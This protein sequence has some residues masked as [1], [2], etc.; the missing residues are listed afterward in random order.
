[1]VATYEFSPNKRRFHN[2]EAVRILYMFIR[3]AKFPMYISYW[4][5]ARRYMGR[6]DYDAAEVGAFTHIL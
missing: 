5:A 4:R 3:H 2:R 1:M 6:V